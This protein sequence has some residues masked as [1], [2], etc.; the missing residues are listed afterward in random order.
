MSAPVTTRL[1][2]DGNLTIY[3]AP[4]GKDSLMAALAGCQTLELDLA[5]VAEIDSAGFQ[6]LVLA[7]QEAARQGKTLNLVAH[8]P[9]VGEVLD[10]F[11]MVGYFGDP[12]LIPAERRP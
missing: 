10:F 3:E 2:L 8:S 11:N 7:K 1:N 5:R 12:L 9:A 6:L 4:A